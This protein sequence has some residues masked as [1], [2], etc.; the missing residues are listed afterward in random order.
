MFVQPEVYGYH[1]SNRADQD[2]KFEMQKNY[3]EQFFGSSEEKRGSMLRQAL[4]G[5][6]I[7]LFSGFV[8]LY[9][10]DQAQATIIPNGPR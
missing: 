2:G 1:I 8:L 10:M 5:G 7:A 6:L 3:F 9:P 4:M